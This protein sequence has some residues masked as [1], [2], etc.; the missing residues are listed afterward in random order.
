LSGTFSGDSY[1]VDKTAPN[2][3]SIVRADANPTSAANLSWT[4]TFDEPVTGVAS[5]N[6]SLSGSGASGTSITGVTGLDSTWTVT[7]STGSAGTLG[8][9]LTDPSGIQDYAGNAS[10]G[11]LTGEAYDIQ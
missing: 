11:T 1:T 10:S 6:F 9:D 4:V 7:A 3:S 8:L 2:V 5:P